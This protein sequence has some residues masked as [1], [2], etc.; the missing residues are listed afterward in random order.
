MKEEGLLKLDNRIDR[1]G[2]VH[3]FV[4]F[5]KVDHS[6]F[7][8]HRNGYKSGLIAQCRQKDPFTFQNI[9]PTPNLT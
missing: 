9:K 6:P 2:S 4:K 7:I 8:I 1:S 3:K 5:R